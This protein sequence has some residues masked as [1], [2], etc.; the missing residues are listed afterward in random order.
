M[1]KI[2]VRRDN[3]DGSGYDVVLH[4]GKNLITGEKRFLELYG[5]I[6]TLEGDL[7]LIAASILAA[8]RCTP[9]GERED[10]VSRGF[11]L[12]I[13]IV[14]IG[15]L[16]PLIDLIES[17]LRTLSHDSWR[18]SF[19]Q[20]N[21]KQ[22]KSSP[23]KPSTG[24]TL[25]FSGGLDSLAAA[26]QFGLQDKK[27]H[28]VSHITKNRQTGDA[29]KQLVAMLKATG[30]S[31]PHLQFFVSSRNG[32]P[33]P[34]ISHDAEN[35]Q[36][37]RSFLFLILGAIAARRAGHR[38]LLMLAE[39]GQMAIH[40]CLSVARV[41]AF[42][43]HTAHPNVLAK[44]EQFI[45]KALLV[46]IKL[47]N[48]YVDM[49]KAE[50]VAPLIKKLPQAIPVSTSCWRNTRLPAAATHC[51]ACIPCMI[52]RIAIEYHTKDSTAYARDTFNED[53]GVLHE[54]DE[55]R[56][57]LVDLTEF[58]VQFETLPKIEIMSNWPDLYSENINAA[59]AISMYRRA[60][61]ESRQVLKKYPK[62]S[63]LL[64]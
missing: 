43:T 25:L 1:T 19:R 53:I 5:G 6:T 23:T 47:V 45:Q 10:Y 60:A 35:S 27:I 28:L 12:S 41:G 37:T 3:A 42:S 40:L 38:E 56:R 33:S 64:S 31:A 11:E 7:L 20:A 24:K 52:R 13:P 54:D 62:L 58:I 22:E 16:Q 51:G 14:N 46:N 49:T 8:D 39:N 48:P 59:S 36:R 50:V 55:A 26:L 17:T 57:N 63:A 34:A 30:I 21:G 44:M 32:Q 4:A 2:F 18:I 15:R 9:R 29:Q 61:K